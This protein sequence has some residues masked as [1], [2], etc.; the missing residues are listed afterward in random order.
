MKVVLDF[1]QLA[2]QL[3]EPFTNIL[4]LKDGVIYKGLAGKVGFYCPGQYAW[5]YT[6]I[7]EA[8]WCLNDIKPQD[9]PVLDFKEFTEL[10]DKPAFILV[11][12]RDVI[13]PG[14]FEEGSVEIFEEFYSI[15]DL[16]SKGWKWCLNSF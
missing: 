8:H 4:V 15:E 14:W 12:R 13:S 3:P 10:P 1:K 6:E 16:I 9:L 11:H 7:P 2:E 5:E